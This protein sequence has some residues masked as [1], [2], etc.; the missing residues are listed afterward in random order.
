MKEQD[1]IHKIAIIILNYNNA[2]DTIA[3]IESIS[4]QPQK[5]FSLIVV[6]NCSTD[7]SISQIISYFN[8]NNLQ[9][10]LVS[11][12]WQDEKRNEPLSKITLL[13]AQQNYG[14]AIGNNLGLQLAMQD[15]TINYFWI[16]NNDTVIHTLALSNIY[17]YLNNNADK[18]EVLGTL[19]LRYYNKDVIQALG[20]KY[21]PIIGKTKLF[22]PDLNIKALNTSMVI[23]V[24]QQAS[25]LIGASLIFSR[26]CLQEVGLFGEEYFLYA[27]EIDFITRAKKKGFGLNLIYDAIVYHK[28]GGTTQVQANVKQERSIFIEY[29]NCRSKL[30]FTKKFY[31]YYYPVVFLFIVSNLFLTYKTNFRNTFTIIKMLLKKG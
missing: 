14:Y 3:C 25:Y 15:E 19:L 23:Q 1:N 21:Y 16:L 28:E 11:E 6:D 7:G 22:Y 8:D 31:P 24:A 29:H 18:K 2:L 26:E 12:S 9:Y 20:G 4:S 17:N 13:K 5:E 27:E 30:I 10:S